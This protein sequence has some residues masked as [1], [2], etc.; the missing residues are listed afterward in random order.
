MRYVCSDSSTLKGGQCV[1]EWATC[2]PGYSSTLNQ[3]ERIVLKKQTCTS[4]EELHG[5]QCRTTSTS[6]PQLVCPSGY[7]LVNEQCEK[8]STCEP[9]L[10]C[11]SSAVLRGDQCVTSV[12][13]AQPRFDCPSGY[14]LDHS[15]DEPRCGRDVP[16]R[17]TRELW[18]T[19]CGHG[20]HHHLRFPDYK[21]KDAP[22]QQPTV[23]CSP[24]KRVVPD[25]CTKLVFVPVVKVPC[26]VGCSTTSSSPAQVVCESGR[27][28]NGM[29]VI[30]DVRPLKRICQTGVLQPDGN[31]LTVIE[32]K[33]LSVC[34]EGV[35]LDNDR[36]VVA[37]PL[38]T[39]EK[40]SQRTPEAICDLGVLKGSVCVGNEAIARPQVCPPGSEDRSS[41]CILAQPIGMAGLRVVKQVPEFVCPNGQIANA[42]GCSVVSVVDPLYGCASGAVEE[43]S[44]CVY[45][46]NSVPSPPQILM[47]APQL[48]CIESG[49]RLEGTRCIE[50]VPFHLECPAGFTSFS[51]DKGRE[52]S[53]SH[54]PILRC[55]TGTQQLGKK[56]IKKRYAP[57]QVTIV[58]TCTKG[59]PGC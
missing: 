15:S 52:C 38:V 17:C 22:V 48:R 23:K 35:S 11:P 26:E 27:L 33:A 20:H 14:N 49:Q 30:A 36:C 19:K 58:R 44:R 43:Q 51:N 3:C 47:S 18:T 12:A 24:T 39:R 42:D 37:V 41:F 46:A 55:P 57:P 9:Q 6:L 40:V 34:P 31:C 53:C 16:Y 29:C 1:S 13:V 8:V 10:R 54:A 7:D 50:S 45:S 59:E 4:D 28:E 56:C 5:R 2:P 25:T 32:R 21:S